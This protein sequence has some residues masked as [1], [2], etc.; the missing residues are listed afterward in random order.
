MS[1]LLDRTGQTHGRLTVLE[2]AGCT[3]GGDARWRCQCACGNIKAIRGADLGK[4]T[5]S[6]GCLQKESVRKKNFKHGNANRGKLSPEYRSWVGMKQRTSDPNQRNYKHY[7]G[8]GISVCEGW[9]NS[10]EQFLTDMGSR[11]NGTSID[12]IDN[13]GNYEPD[14][15]RWATGSEQRRNQRRVS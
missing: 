7:G 5:L 1:K 9:I 14:N 2:Q 4:R 13:D 6:C 11:P 12:R 10:F 3:R 15:C 8:R